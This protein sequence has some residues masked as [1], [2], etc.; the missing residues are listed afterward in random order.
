MVFFESFDGTKIFYE[1]TGSGKPLLF[2]HGWMEHHEFFIHQKEAFQNEYQII[3]HDTRGHGQSEYNDKNYTLETIARDV[4]GILEELNISKTVLFGHSMGGM[5]SQ[6]LYTLYPEKVKALVLIDTVFKNPVESYIPRGNILNPIFKLGLRG[7]RLLSQLINP[8][9]K[10]ARNNPLYNT[11][12]K[13]LIHSGN[14]S[15]SGDIK[16]IKDS[17][18]DTPHEVMSLAVEAMLEFNMEEILPK[19]E[20]PTLIIVGN[21]DWLSPSYV[22]KIMASKIKHSELFILE[23]IGHMSFLDNSEAVNKKI[24]EF[25]KRIDY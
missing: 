6:I 13:Y 3:T 11:I 10:L 21:I 4:N 20:V 8:T 5:V 1:V 7:S 17:L 24:S 14:K 12:I 18:L 19:I 22:H 25:L 15:K 16:L 9:K 23:N 2:T